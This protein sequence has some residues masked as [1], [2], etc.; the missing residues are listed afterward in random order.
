MQI[1]LYSYWRSSASWRI[2]IVLNHKSIPHE[3]I[4]I[5]LLKGEQRGDAYLAVN[6]AGLVPAVDIDGEII[7]ESPAIMEMLEELHPKCPLLPKDPMAR[8]KVRS[9]MNII[10]CDIHPVQNLRL[11][12]V[13]QKTVGK[14][15]FG[16]DVTL[17]DVCLVPQV[18]NA[19]R[20]G[21]D[22]SRF[23]IIAGIDE[24]L[25]ELEAFQLAL[26]SAQI[27]ATSD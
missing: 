26:P 22:M 1:K 16:D 10:C 19:K 14:Y 25:S 12:Q 24:R 11:E 15:C 18:F 8:A 17:A 13:L 5:N 9:I 23:P 21:V 27:D 7:L 20:W 2:R 3:I 6:P 4:P